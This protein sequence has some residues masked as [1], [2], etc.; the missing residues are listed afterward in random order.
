MGIPQRALVRGVLASMGRT[1]CSCAGA[2]SFSQLSQM[3]QCLDR[4]IDLTASFYC[5]QP[6]WK[7]VP[8]RSNRRRLVWRKEEEPSTLSGICSE[9]SAVEAAVTTGVGFS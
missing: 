2:I 7:F 5:V 3:F 8:H 6:E 4:M 1:E 9:F